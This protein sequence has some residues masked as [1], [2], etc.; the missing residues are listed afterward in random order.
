MPTEKFSQQRLRALVLKVTFEANTTAEGALLRLSSGTSV[1]QGIFVPPILIRAIN[2]ESRHQ[3][4]DGDYLFPI[5]ELAAGKFSTNYLL[6]YTG[7]GVPSAD[8]PSYVTVSI[9]PNPSTQRT[10]NLVLQPFEYLGV[11]PFTQLRGGLV[12]GQD[13]LRHRVNLVNRGSDV[14]LDFIDFVSDGGNE[15]Q[16][17]AGNLRMNGAQ[18]CMQFR[19]GSALRVLEN[20]TLHYGKDGAGMLL[21]C[22][23]S[24]VI[25]ER[26]ATL[27][28]GGVWS[29]SECAPHLT[30][31]KAV[32]DLQPGSRL[33]FTKNARLTNEFGNDPSRKLT[34][35]MNGGT[36]DDRALPPAQRAL[37]ERVYPQPAAVFADNVQC[38]PNPFTAYVQLRY[39]AA[40]AEILQLQWIDTQGKTVRAQTLQVPR[41]HSEQTVEAPSEAGVYLLQVVGNAGMT[42]RRL[43]ALGN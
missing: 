21:L 11:Q 32:V 13:T 10:I 38:V 25:L 34:V 7:S 41:G 17:A 4:A 29:L 2:V 6:Q 27:D 22:A 26:N 24:R 30:D 8:N 5:R 43:V 39:T 16:H 31:K 35:L 9:T 28:L 42:T 18:A 1:F 40:S 19:N 37:I 14:C 33:T 3:Q 36:L 12:A 20:A 15:Y 23:T